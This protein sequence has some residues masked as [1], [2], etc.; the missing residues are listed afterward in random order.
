MNKKILFVTESNFS[1]KINRN[2]INMRTDLAWISAL[3]ADHCSFSGGIGYSYDLIVVIIPKKIEKI[4]NVD[5]LIGSLRSMLKEN[6][7]K[8]AVMQEGPNWYYEDYN[9]QDQIKYFNILMGADFILTHNNKDAY[10]YNGLT[11]KPTYVMSSLM[12]EDTIGDIIPTKEEKTIVGGNFVSW[13]GGFPSYMVAR[14]F[15]VPIFSPSMGRKIENESMP[16]LIHLPYMQWTDWMKTLSTFKYAVHLM[17]T[18]AAGTFALN[19]A[20]FS[21]PC[22][23]YEGLDTQLMCHPNLTISDGNIKEAKSLAYMLKND[24]DFYEE[25]SKQAKEQYN[26]FFTEDNFIKRFNYILDIE[27]KN[28]K[29]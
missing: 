14:E 27:F 13:Y 28:E 7:G 2:N 3:D 29:I 4:G 12:I 5:S 26:T 17:R 22:I 24:N 16:G 1:G 10:Y 8:F 19:C 23:G 6:S 21:I 18:H 25:C 15:D 20:Y 11:N 9:M